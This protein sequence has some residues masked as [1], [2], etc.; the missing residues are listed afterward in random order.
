MEFNIRSLEKFKHK[1]SEKWKKG[2]DLN[3][4]LTAWIVC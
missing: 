3:N 1:M 4:K 2:A